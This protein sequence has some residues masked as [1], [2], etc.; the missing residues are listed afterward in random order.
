MSKSVEIFVLFCLLKKIRNFKKMPEKTLLLNTIFL[1]SFLEN[2]YAV[3]I[4]FS[5]SIFNFCFQAKNKR[6]LKG[7]R[8][9]CKST[10]G[11]WKKRKGRLLGS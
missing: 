5:M 4:D 2:L 11:Y 3:E 10:T 1:N 7:N 9:S 8:R 6:K